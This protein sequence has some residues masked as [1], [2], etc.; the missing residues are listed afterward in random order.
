LEKHGFKIFENGVHRKI[1]GPKRSDETGDW[2]KLR[3]EEL[4]DVLPTKYEYITVR[5]TKSKRLQQ[6]RHVARTGEKR[7][8][9]QD[10]DGEG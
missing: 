9:Y 7:N 4:H 1:F 2:R 8:P 10:F 5:V 6:T 3:I